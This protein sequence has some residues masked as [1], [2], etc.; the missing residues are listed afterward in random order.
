MIPTDDE[1][2]ALFFERSES[3]IAYTES[4]YGRLFRMIAMNFL[5]AD[6]ADECVNDAYLRLWNAIPPEKPADLRAYGC[7]TVRNVSLNRA[8]RNASQKRKADLLCEELD[9]AVPDSASLYDDDGL[10][11]ALNAFLRGL[12]HETRVMFTLRYFYGEQVAE[13]AEKTKASETKVRS[14]LFR[15][16]KK[17]KSFLEKEG[18]SL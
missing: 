18:I 4:K 10:K 17:L 6:D 3:A 1:I 13:I 12:D 7:K 15:T 16:R 14:C 5:S 2:I 11:D 9:E 8:E